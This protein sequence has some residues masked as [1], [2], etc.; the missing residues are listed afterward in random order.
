MRKVLALFMIFMLSI[1]SFGCAQKKSSTDDTMN[2]NWDTILKEA[3]GTTVNFYGWGGSKTTN[4]WI[5]DYLTKMLKDKYDITLK[6]VPMNIEDILNKLIGDKQANNKKGTIDVVWING[7]NFY[8][9][10]QAGI[11]YG[12][13]AEKLPNFNKYIDKNSIEVKSDFGYSVEGYE[14][15]YGKAQFVMVYN[16]SKLSKTPASAQELLQFAK[17]NPGKFTYSAPP[18]FTGSAFVRNIIYDTV[19]YDKIANAKPD[20]ASVE[21]VIQPAMDYLKQLKPYL[22]NNGKTYPSTIAQLD[23][24]YADNQLLMSMS[25]NPNSIP[26][27]VKSGEYPKGTKSFIF[28]KGTIGNTHFLAMPYN[29][30][31][32]SGA[33]AVINAII[34]VEAQASKYD[35]EGWGDLP[36]LDNSKLSADEKK[37]FEEIKVGEGVIPQDKLLSHRIP[38]VPAQLVPIIEKIWL[39]QIPGDK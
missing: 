3:K 28:N 35:P 1:G 13:F 27:K 24:M 22:W 16:G 38:E 12:P 31:N 30:P 15:P 25:Y 29:A 39:E 37:K 19:G 34:T 17:E 32:K 20:K 14:V 6:R 11:L 5:D 18:D 2:K 36:V 21:K 8:T 10:K 23:N 26:G 4:A 9:A 33:M 7:E